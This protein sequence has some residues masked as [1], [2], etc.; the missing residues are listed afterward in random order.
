MDVLKA[1]LERI[2]RQLAGLTA[3]QKMLTAALVAIMAITVI[4]WGKYAGESEM[5]PLTTQTFTQRELGNIEQKLSDR[6]FRHTISAD[7]IL[8]PAEQRVQILSYLIFSKA[9]PRG[10]SE[11]MDEILKQRN[12]FDSA[13]TTERIWNHGK[14]ALLTEMIR[15]FPDVDDANVLVNTTSQYRVGASLEPSATVNITASP[16]AKNFQ[17]IADAAAAAVSGAQSG[18]SPRNIKVVINGRPQHVTDPDSNDAID[19]SQQLLVL[20]QY[21]TRAEERVR[22]SLGIDG[23]LVSVAMT[24]NN[25]SIVKDQTEYDAKGVVQKELQSNT[26]TEETNS[27]APPAGGEAATIPNTSVN[28]NSPGTSSP[29]TQSQSREKSDQTYDVKVPETKTHS[30]TPSGAVVAQGATVRVPLS[31]FARVLM[32]NDPTV[33]DPTRKQLDPMIAAE[34]PQLRQ[35]AAM[36][37]GLT[38][39]ELVAI[40]AYVDPAPPT[41]L[42][43]SGAAAP[44]GTGIVSVLVGG[45]AKE[46]ALGALA[47]MSL[48]MASMMVRKGQPS[49]VAAVPLAPQASFPGPPAVLLAGEPIAGEAGSGDTLLDGMELNE[50]AIKAQQM[51]DQ[52]STMVRENPD[53]AATLVKRWLNRT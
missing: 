9:M 41:S 21:E 14:E 7:K 53:A 5:V 32:R 24:M 8:V 4:W 40:S 45:H 23:L 10:T 39:P 20:Q 13:D 17:T 36:A 3:T 25:T 18:L 48:F 6:N 49:P 52:V 43:L 47:L 30:R 22:S 27:S 44:A 37:A 38:S 2:Q 46:I 51:V 12:V 33:K 1:Q 11:A 35:Q 15:S 16:S 26:D 19:A 42:Q 34:I 29:Q 31:Y 28:V 50:E